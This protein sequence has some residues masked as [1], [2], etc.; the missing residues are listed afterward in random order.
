MVPRGI[1]TTE[2]AKPEDKKDM[3]LNLKRWDDVK[4]TAKDFKLP[5]WA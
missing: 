1:D 4:K 5:P 2:V 3:A